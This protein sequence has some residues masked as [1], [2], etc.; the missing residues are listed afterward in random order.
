MDLVCHHF[1]TIQQEKLT[2]ESSQAVGRGPG[3]I[4][5]RHDLTAEDRQRQD[6]LEAA[7]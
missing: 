3:Q 7:C 5:Q 1:E 4:L 6:N 2:G